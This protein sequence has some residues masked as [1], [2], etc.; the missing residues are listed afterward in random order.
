MGD[1]IDYFNILPFKSFNLYKDDFNKGIWHFILNNKDDKY[2][3]TNKCMEFK[4][5][6]SFLIY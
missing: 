4:S 1:I 3:L 6:Q 2:D 5:K